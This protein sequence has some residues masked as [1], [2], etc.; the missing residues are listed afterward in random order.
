M[1]LAAC[2]KWLKAHKDTPAEK[3]DALL[4]KYLGSQAH[5]GGPYSLLHMQQLGPE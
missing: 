1:A 5:G 4:R 2:R 3:R